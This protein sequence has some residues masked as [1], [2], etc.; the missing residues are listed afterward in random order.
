MVEFKSGWGLDPPREKALQFLRGLQMEASGTA[1]TLTLADRYGRDARPRYGHPESRYRQ[2]SLRGSVEV[3]AR[4]ELLRTPNAIP[5]VKAVL[6]ESGIEATDRYEVQAAS[7]M[8]PDVL[9]LSGFDEGRVAIDA[10]AHEHLGVQ[11][12]ANHAFAESAQGAWDEW[13]RSDRDQVDLFH[14]AAS[15]LSQGL[16]SVLGVVDRPVES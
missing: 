12:L 11:A 1:K 2:T 10:L 13:L 15:R 7:R 9:P 3:Y 5:S 14:I 6:S 8:I 4:C 16:L